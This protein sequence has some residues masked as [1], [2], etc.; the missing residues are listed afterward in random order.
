MTCPKAFKQLCRDF[1]V[2]ALKD[3]ESS[4]AMIGYMTEAVRVTFAFHMW[5]LY[6]EVERQA[7][8]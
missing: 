2:A 1:V 5:K 3:E 8:E 4:P 7:A 6:E